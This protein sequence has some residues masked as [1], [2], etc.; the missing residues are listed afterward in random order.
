M[1]VIVRYLLLL[2]AL[3][4]YTVA[5]SQTPFRLVCWNVENY[6]DCDHDSLKNDLDFTPDG[7][8][9]WTYK[10]F[11]QK[12]N[13]IYK[14]LAAIGDTSGQSYTP[15]AIVGLVEVE[16]SK[17]LRE[18]CLNTPL[19]RLGYSFIHYDSPDLRGV[20]CSLLYLPSRFKPIR[21]CPIGV[22]DTAV[23]LYTRDILLVEGIMDDKD[24]LLLLVCHLPSKRG[25]GLADNYRSAIGEKIRFLMDSLTLSHPNSVMVAM[26]DFNASSSEYLFTDVIFRNQSEG[27]SRYYDPVAE[28]PDTIGTYYF[29]GR[30]EYIDHIIVNRPVRVSVFA[31]D[32][33]LEHDDQGRAVRPYR[34]YRGPQYIGGISDH[35]PLY[36]DL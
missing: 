12:R 6:F 16:N 21:H 11:C 25:G 33:L 28:L 10:R 3:V 34:T 31:P 22:S 26:G 14:T 23:G 29:Q 30:W 24:T 18:L 36:F 20:D 13:N 19:R 4:P 8:Y 32:F 15:P 17:V 9:R 7:Q 35:L 2:L 5:P 27:D 1:A